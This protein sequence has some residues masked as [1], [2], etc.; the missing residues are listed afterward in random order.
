MVVP[1]PK[2]RA[3]SRKSVLCLCYSTHMA[4]TETLERFA[5]VPM[6]HRC[7]RCW[8]LSDPANLVEVLPTIART[9]DDRES[10]RLATKA[11]L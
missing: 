3:W 2:T 11:S 6:P 8:L 7:Y 1:T 10:Q 4:V 9:S 5:S